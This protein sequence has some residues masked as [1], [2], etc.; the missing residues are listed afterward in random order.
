[1]QDPA[2]QQ[3]P[4]N[5]TTTREEAL[6]R[7]LSA[8]CEAY[9]QQGFILYSLTRYGE[10]REAFERSVQYNA[11]DVSVYLALAETCMKLDAPD[12]AVTFLKRALSLTERAAP[13]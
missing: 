6:S 1:M 5:G 7:A 10:A 3:P 12:D 11:K 8:H 2:R 4:D 9:K 13:S